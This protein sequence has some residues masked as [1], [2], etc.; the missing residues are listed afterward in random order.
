MRDLRYS[1]ILGTLFY[2]IKLSPADCDLIDTHFTGAAHHLMRYRQST[3]DVAKSFHLLRHRS[4]LRKLMG[5]VF[6]RGDF[7]DAKDR[8]GHDLDDRESWNPDVNQVP[9]PLMFEKMKPDARFSIGEAHSS[10]IYLEEVFE[11]RQIG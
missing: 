9:D 2:G 6:S 10:D 3:S 8:S 7:K 5:L 11:T 4:H 1:E